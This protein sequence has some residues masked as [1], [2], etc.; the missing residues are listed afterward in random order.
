MISN[1][2]IDFFRGKGWWYADEAKGYADALRNVGISDSDDLFYFFVHAEDGPSFLSAHGEL[3]QL[4]W[5]LMNTNYSANLAA[6][7]QAMKI[8]SDLILLSSMEGGGGY[9]YNIEN[10]EVLFLGAGC[11]EKDHKRK[12]WPDINDFLIYFFDL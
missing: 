3:L 10:K 4:G 12:A 2:V 5:H 11:S 6:V 9:F 7:R 8:P 1:Q